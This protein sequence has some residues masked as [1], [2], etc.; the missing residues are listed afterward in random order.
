LV[1]LVQE[2][3]LHLAF[4][5]RMNYRVRWSFTLEKCKGDEEKQNGFGT[6]PKP[7]V[8][9]DSVPAWVEMGR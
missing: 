1:V 6:V 9:M 4:N 7:L 3:S 8:N 5:E 2:K